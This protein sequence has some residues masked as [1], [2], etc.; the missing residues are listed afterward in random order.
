MNELNVLSDKVIEEAPD[1]LLNEIKSELRIVRQTG[2]EKDGALMQF[3][4]NRFNKIETQLKGIESKV[5]KVLSA[6]NEIQ[7][8]LKEIKNLPREDEDKLRR[9]Y[10]SIDDKLNALSDKDSSVLIVASSLFAL[11]ALATKPW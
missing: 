6:I 7:D 5:D 2:F 4:E 8:S 3:L 9:I 10:R 1:S 11:A